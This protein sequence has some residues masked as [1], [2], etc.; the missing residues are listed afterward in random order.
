MYM[1]DFSRTLF[2]PP[3]PVPPTSGSMRLILFGLLETDPLFP[4]LLRHPA[5]LVVIFLI[6][7]PMSKNNVLVPDLSL[8]LPLPIH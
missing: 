7:F 4:Y 8:L 2:F 5:R 3:A 1:G 6:G